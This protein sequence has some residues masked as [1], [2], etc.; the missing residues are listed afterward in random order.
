MK[1]VNGKEVK[2]AFVIANLMQ[3]RKKRRY[4]GK[5]SKQEFDEQ[6]KNTRGKVLEFSEKKLDETIH[7]V[8]NK[9]LIAYNSCKWF[10]G[11]IP[12]DKV[13]V[14]RRAGGLPH[15][16][17]NVS[18]EETSE[19]VSH[20]L[21]NG[22][23]LLKNRPRRAIV[24]MLRINMSGMQNE[25]YLYPIVF[26]DGAGTRPRKRLRKSR[27]KYAIDDGNMRSIA[28]ALSGK[29][30]IKSYVGISKKDARAA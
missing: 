14:W 19:K 12:I 5:I 17:T 30:K 29:K 20:A 2:R 6:L 24:N 26:E 25:K 10:V 13:G 7:S 9:R 16:W 4:L 27:M 15:S 8:W 1:K 11:Y 3:R 22:S 28:L 18:L 23:G 21:K